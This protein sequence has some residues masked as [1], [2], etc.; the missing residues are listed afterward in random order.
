MGSIHQQLRNGFPTPSNHDTTT[1]GGPVPP[2]S[3]RDEPTGG[4]HRTARPSEN[5]ALT[6][7][8][9][10]YVLS[11]SP[12]ATSEAAENGTN[13]SL[14]IRLQ[15][16]H[17][18]NGGVANSDHELNSTVTVVAESVHQSTVHTSHP[19]STHPPSTHPPSTHPPSTHSHSTHPF[20]M[21]PPSAHQF[22]THPSPQAIFPPI[23]APS[24]LLEA[25]SLP[26]A[27]S[28]AASHRHML[29]SRL[30]FQRR[31]DSVQEHVHPFDHQ[32]FMNGAAGLQLFT[33][34]QQYLAAAAAAQQQSQLSTA[35]SMFPGTTVFPN[36]YYSM[37]FMYTNP[38]LIAP[39]QQPTALSQQQAV[40]PPSTPSTD[41]AGGSDTPVAAAAL[42]YMVPAVYDHSGQLV[43]RAGAAPGAPPG[44]HV[45]IM[46]PGPIIFNS[47]GVR[48]MTAGGAQA[49]AP[50]QGPA[51][52]FGAG[53]NGYASTVTASNDPVVSGFP[54]LTPTVAAG[55]RLDS[56][57][58]GFSPG[59]DFKHTRWPGSF[60]ASAA[61]ASIS[62]TPP[63]P[64]DARYRVS[65]A[66]RP[67][68][69]N[70]QQERS[71]G[72]SQL[73]EEFRNNQLPNLQ[74][75]DLTGHCREFARDQHGSRFI[76]QRL[77]HA[78]ALERQAVFTEILSTSYG[79]MNDV[80]GNYVI[81]KFFEFGSVEQRA[82]LVQRICGH[83]LPLSTQMYGCR[84]V[85]K[86]LETVSGEQQRALIR[87]LDGHVLHCVRD[88]NG[89]HVVQKCVECVDSDALQFVVDAFRGHVHALSSHPYGCRVM[90]RILEHCSSDQTAPLLAELHACVGQLL[91]DQYGN[92]VVQHVVERGPD[93]D[94]ARVIASLT[95]RLVQLSQHKFASNVVEKAV[96]FGSRQQRAL[97]IDEV[98]ELSDSALLSVMKDQFG[99][100]VIQKMI[101]VAESTHKQLL[102]Q[103]L[104]SHEADLKCYTFGKHILAK[105]EKC[106]GRGGMNGGGGQFNETEGQLGSAELTAI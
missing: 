58:R 8:M 46:S 9:V 48:V 84:V 29:S 6:V 21:H 82:T 103:K 20:S 66:G 33:Q 31:S 105:L 67:R 99:N 40:A 44:N 53:A 1:N 16:L 71:G 65:G 89:N 24:I 17:L 3:S 15:S 75:R 57:E 87:E 5:G 77:E 68:R 79:L 32:R 102:V 97:L 18:T 64:T 4:S 27:P 34:H 43:L 37:P 62:G 78:S 54:G 81:Q 55:H 30:P 91:H 76:Q 2:S 22:S 50:G 49:Q 60:T 72:R 59:L 25:Q 90:Q 45:R 23:G 11:G 95:N 10:E 100:Y 98:C 26:V 42:Q 12:T 94:R 74:L 70:Q 106:C 56:L 69:C 63:P 35:A 38:G 104:K 41:T 83:V 93:G 92:Y 52:L 88:Q 19:P 85:Q 80:F 101:E 13:N 36:H 73:L 39:P 51:A 14:D 47:P 96:M 7:K 61:V 86:A 28:L